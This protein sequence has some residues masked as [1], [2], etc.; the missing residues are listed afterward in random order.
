[1]GRI[2]SNLSKRF[3]HATFRMPMISTRDLHYHTSQ[4][5]S[6]FGLEIGKSRSSQ[7]ATVRMSPTSRPYSD[8]S[9]K[10]ETGMMLVLAKDSVRFENGHELLQ[11]LETLSA[12]DSSNPNDLGAR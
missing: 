8:H 9:N 7:H 4:Q 2:R 12:F 6:L 11:S 3:Q 5:E 10:F 1:M